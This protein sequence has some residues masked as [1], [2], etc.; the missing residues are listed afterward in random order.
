MLAGGW[1]RLSDRSCRHE[2]NSP[3]VLSLGCLATPRR[4]RSSTL[5]FKGCCP[6]R[7][8]PRN[9]TRS[10]DY[11]GVSPQASSRTN[12]ARSR[13][14]PRH[15]ASQAISRYARTCDSR[16]R[17]VHAIF[18]WLLQ[19]RALLHDAAPRTI[20]VAT[21]PPV[22]GGISRACPWWRFPGGRQPSEFANEIVSLVRHDGDR[23]SPKLHRT[24]THGGVRSDSG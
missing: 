22:G 11:D 8:C 16:R 18:R 20:A 6:T 5:G 17:D 13:R 21:K 15:S 2:P 12:G 7:S 1:Q 10:G 23:R 14:S 19:Y 9:W 24:V 4:D 3:L